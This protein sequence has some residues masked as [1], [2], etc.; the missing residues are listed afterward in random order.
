MVAVSWSTIFRWSL[1]D[2]SSSY[3][4]IQGDRI[5]E[6]VA[7]KY[8]VDNLF[9]AL[10]FVLDANHGLCKYLILPSGIQIVF[11][12]ITFVKKVKKIWD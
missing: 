9:E 10:P 4:S 5:D 7:E 1:V 12:D 3:I 8:G 6:L 2:M 11:P